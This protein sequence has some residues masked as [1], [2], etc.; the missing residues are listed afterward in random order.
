MLI[1]SKYRQTFAAKA[2]V[3]WL[4]ARFL[5][6]DFPFD[7]DFHLKHLQKH[8]NLFEKEASGNINHFA[9]LKNS[10]KL[11]NFYFKRKTFA[12]FHLIIH[13]LC[14]PPTVFKNFMVRK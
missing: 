8:L 6:P 9:M 14:F 10:R 13:Q 2:K 4:G 12:V 7:P 5:T 3:W 1:S 11:N